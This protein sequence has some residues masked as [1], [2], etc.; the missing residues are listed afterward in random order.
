M[1]ELEQYC[2]MR[3]SALRQYPNFARVQ[4][5]PESVPLYFNC[6]LSIISPITPSAW[7]AVIRTLRIWLWR[8]SPF[9]RI[10]T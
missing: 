10:F 7:R 8:A 3:Y 2:V 1:R 5:G 9:A 6:Q 4:Y